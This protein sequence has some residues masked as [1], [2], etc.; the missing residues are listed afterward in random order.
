MGMVPS[1]VRFSKLSHHFQT[2]QKT[3]EFE[4]PLGHWSCW[5]QHSLTP[6]LKWNESI[7]FVT[8]T[9]TFKSRKPPVKRKWRSEEL[10]SSPGETFLHEEEKATFSPYVFMHFIKARVLRSI[11]MKNIGGELPSLRRREEKPLQKIIIYSGHWS[12][13]IY[14]L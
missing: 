12:I 2:H 6:F 4:L 14:F 1:A 8:D 9:M 11:P 10:T 5:R 3:A 13:F 7:F